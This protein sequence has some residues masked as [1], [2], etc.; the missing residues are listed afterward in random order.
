MDIRHGGR[1]MNRNIAKSVIGTAL[2]GLW[3]LSIGA[4]HEP[5][6]G[7][8]DQAHY[9]ATQKLQG[10]LFHVQ[11]LEL[12]Q[13]HVF[14]TSVDGR[15]HRAWLHRFNRASGALEARIDLTDGGRYH[16]GGMS[17]VGTSLWVPVAEPRA[18]SSARL[19]EIDSRAMVVRRSIVIPD[20][21]G[22]VAARPGLLV[23]G[24]WDSRELYLIDPDRPDQWRRIANPS[25][26]RWQDM[27]FVGN[28]L[29]AGGYTSPWSGTIDWIDWPAM[30]LVRSIHDGAIG[31]I[32]PFGR[33][34]AL[35]GEGMA[36]EGRELYLLP[37]D[38]P[39]RVFHFRLD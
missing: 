19:L 5:F 2:I 11:G 38:G 1:R 23:A 30:K 27:K 25:S 18:H 6:A 16:V 33:G 7:A 29:V 31:A 13:A 10:K 22:C 37:E 3:C 9:V 8:I 15:H 20:H 34:G 4:A 26:T 35:S 14:A 24:N 17:L 21:L 39:G 12:D 36:I 32:R 28:Q